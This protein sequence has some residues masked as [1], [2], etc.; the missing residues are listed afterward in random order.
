MGSHGGVGGEV[1]ID[2]KRISSLGRLRS[3]NGVG[4]GSDG[5]VSGCRVQVGASGWFGS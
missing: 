1:L 3:S 4:S 2:E 5:S